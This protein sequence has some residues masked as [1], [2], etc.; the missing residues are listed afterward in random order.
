MLTPQWQQ[1]PSGLIT[2]TVAPTQP[3]DLLGVYLTFSEIFGFPADPDYPVRQLRA[4]PLGVVVQFCAELLNALS[5]PGA[6]HVDLDRHFATQWLRDPFRTRVLNLLRDPRRALLVPQALML[7]AR[8]AVEHSPD[9]LPD[10]AEQGNLVGA[11][12]AFSDLMGSSGPQGPTVIADQPGELGR[13]II[14]NQY[15]NN[16]TSVAHTLTRYVRRWRNGFPRSGN[17]GGMV[18]LAAVY[19]ECTGVTLDDLTIVAG[20]LWTAAC[21]GTVLTPAAELETLLPAERVAGALSLISADPDTLR[22]AV[23]KERAQRH[24]EWT[25]D[26]FQQYPVVR[27]DDLLLVVDQ[28]Y[29]IDRAFGWLPINDIRFPPRSR[30]RPAGHK[31]RAEQA[32]HTL[33][34]L[35][36]LYVSEVLHS[37]TGQGGARRVYDDAEL[38]TAFQ[39]KN[40][41][42]A[43]AALDY[44]DTWI[45]V[46]VT[47]SQL[48]RDAATAVPGNAQ[49]NDIDKLLEEV[50]QIDATIQALRQ[51]ESRLTGAANPIRRT[52]LPL[53]LLTEGFPVNPVSMTVI[54]ERARQRGLL[55]GQDVM[56][57]EVLDVE[58]LEL[59]E[60]LQE[61]Q[62]VSLL[63]VIQRKQASHLERMPMR[64]FLHATITTPFGHPQ[65]FEGKVSEA[66]RPLETVLLRREQPN[67]GRGSTAPAAAGQTAAPDRPAGATP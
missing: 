16:S 26:A 62:G 5:Q 55:E 48:Q 6:S 20:A 46:E 60:A 9:T 65:R 64:S 40:Q 39:K 12:L 36:E 13:E 24:T 41:K 32:V 1:R 2:P 27:L 8:A 38:K 63:T 25:F 57:L 66:L 33:R 19:E 58:E 15:F 59:I 28:R 37:I 51:G 50:H 11:L 10:R 49:A 31:K 34:R 67:P 14:A 17:A 23:Q 54:R 21:H 53:L 45:V 30:P 4:L 61:Q 43:D 52:Y 56:P 22:H 3:I 7:L 47:T 35:S 18:D 29:L 42:I 44:G